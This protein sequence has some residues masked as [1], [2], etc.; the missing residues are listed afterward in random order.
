LNYNLKSQIKIWQYKLGSSGNLIT[1]NADG[2][3]TTGNLNS[4][5]GANA[6]FCEKNAAKNVSTNGK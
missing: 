3:Y 4:N 5:I 6:F 2:T 1:V